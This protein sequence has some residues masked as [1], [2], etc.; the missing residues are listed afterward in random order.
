[1]PQFLTKSEFKS[2]MN[3]FF[4]Q[5]AQNGSFRNVTPNGGSAS[6]PVSTDLESENTK[7]KMLVKKM[8]KSLDEN[9]RELNKRDTQ[10]REV[11]SE[12][13]Q[14]K[15]LV[16]RLTKEM[17]SVKE[18]VEFVQTSLFNEKKMTEKLKRKLKVKSGK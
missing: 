11:T 12:R 15:D 8:E 6:S 9:L 18:H 2:E 17:E 3:K 7:L 5:M 1:M 10:L 16:R 14:Y 4:S 13:D